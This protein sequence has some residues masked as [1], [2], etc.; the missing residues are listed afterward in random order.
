MRGLNQEQLTA[1]RR[2]I[3]F[4]FQAHNLFD[5]LTARQ[6]VRTSLLPALTFR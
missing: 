4:I 5:S 1:V 3:G 6:N 2:N